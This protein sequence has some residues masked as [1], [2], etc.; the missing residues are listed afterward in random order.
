MK[1]PDYSHWNEFDWESE[2][3]RDDARIHAYIGELPRFIDLPGEDDLMMKR[4][5]RDPELIPQNIDWGQAPINSVFDEDAFDE[6]FPDMD[7]WRNRDGADCLMALQKLAKQWCLAFA[8][9][10]PGNQSGKGMGI[11]AIYGKITAHLCDITDLSGDAYL[12]LKKALCKRVLDELNH[13]IGE[14]AEIG[15]E[16][17]SLEK[18]ID[19]HRERLQNLR[20]KMVDLLAK[21]RNP[22]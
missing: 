20:E 6:E 4:M 8:S 15:E 16:T 3:R 12:S 22:N 7:E 11:I 17:P 18:L 13:L 19:E 21:L 2:L 9:R 1:W 14:L 5:Q 10:I